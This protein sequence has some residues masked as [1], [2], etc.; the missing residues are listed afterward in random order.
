[1]STTEKVT[2]LETSFAMS[3]ERFVEGWTPLQVRL[4]RDLFAAALRAVDA[5]VCSP[6]GQRMHPDALRF[7]NYQRS[8]FL[9]H[10]Q[11]LNHLED[12]RRP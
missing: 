11:L 8:Q 5:F 9:Q 6:K 4:H 12:Q 10:A 7:W 1:M 3:I 2:R